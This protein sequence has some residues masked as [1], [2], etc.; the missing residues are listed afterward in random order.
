[1]KEPNHLYIAGLVHSAQA[2]SSD[3]FAEIYALTYNKTY[4]Y[5]RHYLRDDFLAQDALQEIYISALKNIHSLNAPTL[6]I[7]W[8]NRISFNVCFDISQKNR[9]FSQIA[10]TEILELVCCEELSCN[11]EA[12]TEQKDEYNRLQ[13]ALS[14]LPFQEKQVLILRYYQDLKLEEIATALGISRSTVKRHIASGQE[15]LKKFLKG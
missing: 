7:A 5:A 6:F 9:Q 8:L 11:P 4:N 1:M 2:G 10:N 14:L 12:Q 3:A 13:K 15:N